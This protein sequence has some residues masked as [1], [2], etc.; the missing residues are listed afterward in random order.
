MILINEYYKLIDI[1]KN[2]KIVDIKHSE[3]RFKERLPELDFCIWKDT[4]RKGIDK[5][6]IDYKDN[7][8]NYIIVNNKYNFGIQIHWR[9]DL[10]STDKLNHAFTSTTLSNKEMKY[11]T[12]QDIK[13]FVE[14]LKK[15]KKESY[16]KSYYRLENIPL[17]LREIHYDVF[18]E[19]GKV[20]HTF[21][22]IEV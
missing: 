16:M 8:D 12:K 18:I 6:L 22:I 5:I 15:I 17:E 11:V 1:Y 4:I 2:R 14:H 7:T 21:E 19:N 13:V 20:F 3:A 9:L 10:K